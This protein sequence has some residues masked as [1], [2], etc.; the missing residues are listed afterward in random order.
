MPIITLDEELSG[1]IRLAVFQA[2][3]I[4]A[5]GE[6]PELERDLGALTHRLRQA[7]AQPPDA[8][9][10]LQPGRELYRALGLDPTKNRPSSEALIRR[11][12]KGTGLYRINRVVD[13]CNFCSMQIALSIGLYD[14]GE[15]RWPVA[16]RRGRAGEGYRGLGKDHVSVAD[17]YALVDQEGPFGNPSSDSFRTRIREETSSC[18]FVIFAPAGYGEAR[19]QAELEDCA[20]RMVRY[21]GGEVTRREIL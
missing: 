4:T 7:Y 9:R 21:N 3:G 13:T 17:R 15:V 12:I 8:L 6:S 11:V 1:K 14:T 10:L 5:R 20:Q 2:E 16:L 18:T 19:L